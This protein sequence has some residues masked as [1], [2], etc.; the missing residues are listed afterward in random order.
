M[1]RVGAIQQGAESQPSKQ[2]LRGWGVENRIICSVARTPVVT[3]KTNSAVHACFGDIHD[4]CTVGVDALIK[5][6]AT[7]AHFSWSL[8]YYGCFFPE[9]ANGEFGRHL[10]SSVL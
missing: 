6:N 7:I 5:P 3:I 2:M 10:D 9:K 8:L 4:T 1:E